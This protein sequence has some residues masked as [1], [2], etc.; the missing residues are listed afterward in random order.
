M[1]GLGFWLWTSDKSRSELERRY[2]V[3]PGNLRE[4]AGLRVHIRDTAGTTPR[5][6]SRSERREY[7]GILGRGPRSQFLGK[8]FAEL[9]LQKRFDE[10]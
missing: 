2:L 4:V 7:V 6:S 10:A 9:G 5:R 3:T 8:D 1:T